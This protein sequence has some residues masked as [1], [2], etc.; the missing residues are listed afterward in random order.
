MFKSAAVS[1]VLVVGLLV[2]AGGSLSLATNL[3]L[4]KMLRKLEQ[5]SNIHQI[6]R[7]LNHARPQRR[8]VL[9]T[10]MPRLNANGSSQRQKC[11]DR[12][13]RRGNSR[14]MIANS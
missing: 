5:L 13:A 3:R 6:R 7:Q 2:V 9:R 8:H 14:P 1:L 10:A 4:E 11:F 12:S